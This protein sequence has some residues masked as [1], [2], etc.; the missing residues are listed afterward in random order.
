MFVIPNA[1]LKNPDV[2]AFHRAGV[3]LLK[4]LASAIG[5]PES[6]FEIEATHVTSHN[7][8]LLTLR[9]SKV[10][11]TLFMDESG[12]FAKPRLSYRQSDADV[13]STRYVWLSSLDETSR[14]QLVASIR[15]M[16]RQRAALFGSSMVSRP[17]VRLHA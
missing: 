17:S 6:S 8:G 4:S 5:L 10:C 12:H 16:N 1:L 11:F 3:T 15:S 13:T 14:C 2:A 9:S 7:V